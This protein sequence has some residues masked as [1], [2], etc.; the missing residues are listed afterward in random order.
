MR[1]RVLVTAAAMAVFL[2]GCSSVNS[3]QGLTPEQAAVIASQ[4]SE[5]ASVAAGE[6]VQQLKTVEIADELE[7]VG[8]AIKAYADLGA[9]MERTGDLDLATLD[10]LSEGIST[11]RTAVD[12]WASYAA[13]LPESATTPG[14]R[15]DIDAFTT[16]ADAYVA[17]QEDGYRVWDQC[18]R[19]EGKRDVAAATCIFDEIDVEGSVEVFKDYVAALKALGAELGM[20][21]T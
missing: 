2:A 18:L 17:G 20:N 8:L 7:K 15:Q 11:A 10:K 4:A 14:L 5:A 1:W 12:E 13:S 9:E 3:T 21:I 19:T 16:A 6:A